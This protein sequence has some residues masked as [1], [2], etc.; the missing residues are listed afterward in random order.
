MRVLLPG[1]ASTTVMTTNTTLLAIDTGELLLGWHGRRSGDA[2]AAAQFSAA[3]ARLAVLIPL[4]LGFLFG[5]AV[6]AIGY[7]LFGLWC[8]VAVMAVLIGLIVWA[9]RT[10]PK[11]VGRLS[12]YRSEAIAACL[13]SG[14]AR[15]LRTNPLGSFA[16]MS[17]GVAPELS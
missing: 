8:L 15:S 3:R 4:G 16:P 6:G 5:T 10:G 1:V 14:N 12:L 7:M 2:Q 13:I 9:A 17:N 11:S